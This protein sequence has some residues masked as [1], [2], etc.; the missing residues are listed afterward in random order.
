MYVACVESMELFLSRVDR[1]RIVPTRNSIK[2][3]ITLFLSIF[4]KLKLYYMQE[5]I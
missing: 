2:K 1:G 3:I 4:L 5:R